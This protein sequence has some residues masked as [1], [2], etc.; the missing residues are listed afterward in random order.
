MTA[1][2]SA[3][4]AMAASATEEPRVERDHVF[5]L[6]SDR[7]RRREAVMGCN[8]LLRAQLCTGA[9]WLS[10][11]EFTRACASVGLVT[12]GVDRAVRQA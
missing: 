4:A 3:G 5:E 10:D 2:N 9:H 12:T 1:T 11:G 6:A 7:L 8:N